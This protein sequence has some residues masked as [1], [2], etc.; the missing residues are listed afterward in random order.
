SPKVRPV[1]PRG[2]GKVDYE[3]LD[4][5]TIIRNNPTTDAEP[6]PMAGNGGELEYLD[7]PAF[8]RRQAD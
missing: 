5:P 7:I 2:D 3:T 6:L 8:L 1:S 4:R